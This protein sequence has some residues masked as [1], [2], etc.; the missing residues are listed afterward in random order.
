MIGTEFEW[1]EEKYRTSIEKHSIS[2]DLTRFIFRNPH[3]CQVDNRH[4]Y[5][6]TRWQAI[7]SVSDI[8]LHVTYTKRGRWIGCDL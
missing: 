3:L 4:D 2:F 7:G 1:D 8:I 5:R 6:E